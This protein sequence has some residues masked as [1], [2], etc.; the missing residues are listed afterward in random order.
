M[1]Q[2]TIVFST[3]LSLLTLLSFCSLMVQ[4]QNSL[5]PGTILTIPEMTPEQK[6]ANQ[7]KALTFIENVLPFDTTKYNIKTTHILTSTLCSLEATDS[8]IA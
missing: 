3:I 1:K 6:A 7:E 2:L 5:T 4:A 8:K